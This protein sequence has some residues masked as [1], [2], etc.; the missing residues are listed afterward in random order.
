MSSP[1]AVLRKRALNI[2]STVLAVGGGIAS[3]LVALVTAFFALRKTVVE[4]TAAENQT[5]FATLSER[6]KQVEIDL[7]A[8]RLD[9]QQL[10]EDLL[11][12]KGKL[13]EARLLCSE[14]ERRNE[15]LERRNEILEAG[16]TE[17]T[18]HI[19]KLELRIEHL[20]TPDLG[21]SEITEPE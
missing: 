6:L 16:R 3:F 5:F 1:T 11:S 8:E 9:S 7:K 17:R 14:L 21:L 19:R 10:R 13:T 2:D 20:E 12:M 15:I 18:E 4:A